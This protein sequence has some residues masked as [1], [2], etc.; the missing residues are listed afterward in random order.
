M[1]KIF[2]NPI[3]TF[4]LGITIASSSAFAYD[5]FANDVGYIP[6]DTNWNVDNVSS[7]LDNLHNSIWEMGTFDEPISNQ[8]LGQLTA[9]NTSIT[10]NK[11]KYIILATSNYGY[12][13]TTESSGVYT[14]DSSL[15]LNYDTSKCD[16]KDISKKHY[17]A[18]ASNKFNNMYSITRF[19]NFIYYAEVNEDNVAIT[20]KYTGGTDNNIALGITLN[21][22][23]LKQD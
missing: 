7:A 1:K 19:Q 23:K 13:T 3:F 16:I 12:N 5:L 20:L 11:G 9:K 15:V 22:I 14:I 17:R 4:I 18:R 21:A 10:L 8:N 6:S 2:K